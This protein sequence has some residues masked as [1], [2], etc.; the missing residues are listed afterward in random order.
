MQVLPPD[1]DWKCH[2]IRPPVTAW[3]AAPVS[4]HLGKMPHDMS[5]NCLVLCAEN[6]VLCWFHSLEEISNELDA[7][8]KRVW[9]QMPRPL[10][11]QRY[12]ALQS[13]SFM[14]ACGGDSCL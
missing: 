9:S 8:L 10:T 4:C 5:Q 6:M 13:M 12:W 2:K 3:K 7:S 1:T 11:K 14:L